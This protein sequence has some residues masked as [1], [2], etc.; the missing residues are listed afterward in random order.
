MN[1]SFLKIM[2]N[3]DHSNN[4]QHSDYSLE[5]PAPLSTQKTLKFTKYSLY[6][7]VLDGNDLLPDFKTFVIH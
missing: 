2:I 3:L 7:I 5:T 6:M 4:K 1:P